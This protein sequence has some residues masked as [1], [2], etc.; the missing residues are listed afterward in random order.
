M[1]RKL[2]HEKARLGAAYMSKT[3]PVTPAVGE[4]LSANKYK[5]LKTLVV[6]RP[7]VKWAR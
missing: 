7:M 1:D 6:S 2:W 3:L 5:L 4:A